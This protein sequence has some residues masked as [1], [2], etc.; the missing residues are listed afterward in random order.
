M[1]LGIEFRLFNG[2]TDL[3]KCSDLVY[4]KVCGETNSVNPTK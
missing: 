1:E 3:K 4:K 2:W